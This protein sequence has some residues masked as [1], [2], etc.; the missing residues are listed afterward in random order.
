MN[1]LKMLSVKEDMAK[2][3]FLVIDSFLMK[4]LG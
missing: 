2:Y 4:R 1:I 3:Y